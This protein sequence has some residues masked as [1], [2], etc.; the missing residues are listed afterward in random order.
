MFMV[1]RKIIHTFASN[2]QTISIRKLAAIV[3][4]LIAGMYVL[5]FVVPRPVTF[6][7]AGEA[8]VGQLT[9]F[10]DTQRTSSNN[11]NTH[12]SGGLSIG[13]T[14]IATTK[15]CFTP[16]TAPSEGVANIVTA[17]WGWYV[18]RSHYKLT[19]PEPP[20]VVAAAATTVP[21][22]ITQPVIYTID[23]TDTVFDYELVAAE[24]TSDC[25]VQD[26]TVNC[27]LKNLDLAQGAEHDVTLTRSF[28]DN[29]GEKL[30]TTTVNILPAVTITDSSPKNNQTI[31][32][33]PT[34][35]S[36]VADKKLT[37]A[38]A[39]LAQ[40]EGDKETTVSTSTSVAGH[41]V[42]VAISAELAREKNFR[43]TLQ[44]AEAED[45]STIPESYVV[46]FTTS[47]GPKVT[48]I[49]VGTSGVDPNARI[50][51]TL[52]QPIA[53]TVDIMK[54]VRIS[55]V[56][57]VISK[58]GSQL[59]FNVKNAA[60]CAT[61]SI[62]IDK[63]ITSATNGLTSKEGWS[64]SSR[65]NCRAT[66]TIGYSVKGRPIVA[67]Y[68]G[69]G[70]T[71]ILFTGGMHGSEPS[72]YSTMLAW[73][74]HL[75]SNADK[76]PAGRQVVIVPNVNP[77]GIA[78]NSRYNA[79][80]VNIARNFA[81][82]DWKPDIDT[83]SGTLVGGGGS[84]PMSEPETKA[85]GA[86]TLQLN[87]RL[88]V[89]YHAAGR[90]VG[91]NDVADSRSIG[92][93]YASTVGYSTMFGSSAEDIMGYGFSGQYEDYIGQKLG[94]PAILIELPTA[95]GNYLNSQLNVLWKMVNI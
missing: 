60:R 79:R 5:L 70:A 23:Q 40:V 33:K 28:N 35:F 45:G 91:A 12:Y 9:F 32:D 64:Y 50:V 2:I 7:Y 11:F 3:G 93:L 29:T 63:G 77:D 43:L 67:Y 25:N 37:G 72:G 6:S 85:L 66:A 58:Q 76:I 65:I 24:K 18:F 62:A 38:T 39:R 20:R 57:A 13:K 48:S 84:A 81:T 21:I 22:A 8:C 34:S 46:S 53:D 27:S 82:S 95:S 31:F 15:L 52:D 54:F 19:V 69:S 59:L 83:T 16:E 56:N 36:F 49:N 90:L 41:T 61:F 14:R 71:T 73:A 86:L 17:P 51:V 88:E 55:G 92:S 94:K 30:L 44:N 4:I 89:S 75:D 68:Y 42:T 80:N 10:P 26:T 47:G 1:I 78:A 74:N 87:P